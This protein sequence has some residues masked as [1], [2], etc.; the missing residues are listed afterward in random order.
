MTWKSQG[1]ELYMYA[2]V[3]YFVTPIVNK[4]IEIYEHIKT[5]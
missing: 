3:T 1:Y 4:P 2:Y 5:E